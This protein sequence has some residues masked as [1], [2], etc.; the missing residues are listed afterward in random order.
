MFYF[1][2][3]SR[4]FVPSES[5]HNLT[6]KGV[7]SSFHWSTGKDP[8]GTH[9][10]DNECYGHDSLTWSDGSMVSTLEA[11]FP[12]LWGKL[13]MARTTCPDLH[14]VTWRWRDAALSG[15]VYC[16]SNVGGLLTLLRCLWW[17]GYGVTFFITKNLRLLTEFR[18]GFQLW[19]CLATLQYLM[20]FRPY[21]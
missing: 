14:H 15:L 19:L 20:H 3:G 10:C 13:P 17:M 18:E 6:K 4:S 9:I 2:R 12:V 1:K 8:P 16:H 21:S 5:K 7:G 11:W